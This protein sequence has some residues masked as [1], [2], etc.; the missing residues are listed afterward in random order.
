MKGLFSL[1][2]FVSYGIQ[3]Y[4]LITILN[5]SLRSTRI[6]QKV[7]AGRLDLI[8]RVIL[9][10]LTCKCHAEGLHSLMYKYES[11][12]MVSH[13]LR[14]KFSYLEFLAPQKLF[15][16]LYW[17]NV[18]CYST[19]VILLFSMTYSPNGQTFWKYGL[20]PPI[21]QV[22]NTILSTVYISDG[23]AAIFNTYLDLLISLIGAFTSTALT[24]IFPPLLDT[25][26]QVTTLQPSKL[27]TANIVKNMLILLLGVVGSVIGT[28]TSVAQL[29]DQL[30]KD[31]SR[32]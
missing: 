3:F 23:M 29:V 20:I 27:R 32:K 25:L 10:A 2:I 8:L 22:W 13:D 16:F 30:I 14:K 31:N 12:V 15:L 21:D 11:Q 9:V 4:V 28:Y 7:G 17:L 5:D 26:T 6:A 1:C 18:H 24:L 19:K